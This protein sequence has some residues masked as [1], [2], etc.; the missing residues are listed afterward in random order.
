M[1]FKGEHTKYRVARFSE[2]MHLCEVA[3]SYL[4]IMISLA[5]GE[6]AKIEQG[7][8]EF[9]VLWCVPGQIKN[10]LRKETLRSTIGRITSFGEFMRE[11]LGNHSQR[12]RALPANNLH[13][14]R[15]E[16]PRPS[17]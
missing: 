9:C 12:I 13:I 5:R 15:Q 6:M 10:I 17:H 3:I 7:S 11:A 4:R 14:G 8:T 16:T 2:S 1:L